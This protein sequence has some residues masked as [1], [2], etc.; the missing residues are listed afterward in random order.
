MSRAASAPKR[1]EN[2][3]Q[4][5]DEWVAALHQFMNQAQQWAER[6]GWGVLREVKAL[7]DE[8]FGPYEAPQLL[9]HDTFG[10]V[11]LDPAARFV[12]GADGVID[13]FAIPSWDGLM[14]ARFGGEWALIHED[15]D[16]PRSPWTEPVFVET[17]KL[18]ATKA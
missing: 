2:A 6:Q 10:R 5:R 15:A 1:V 3:E 12:S 8:G 9:I 17:T 18:L 16:G 13:F 7:E 11:L 14:I 4:V